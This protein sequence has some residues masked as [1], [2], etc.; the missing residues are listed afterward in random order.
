MCP[1]TQYYDDLGEEEVKEIVLLATHLIDHVG[2]S[3][4]SDNRE[5]LFEKM[6]KL[7]EEE[8]TKVDE[9]MKNMDVLLRMMEKLKRA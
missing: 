6:K 4:G 8:Q 5:A 7:F 3:F 9:H 2:V 1:F